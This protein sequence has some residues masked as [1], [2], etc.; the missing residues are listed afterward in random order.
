[1]TTDDFQIVADVLAQSYMARRLEHAVEVGRIA[2]PQS[3][4]GRQLARLRDVALRGDFATRI[5]SMGLLL[6]AAL[7]TRD[8][9]TLFVPRLVRPA[10]SPILQ[11]DVLV[12]SLVL[13]TMAPAV[14]RAWRWSRLRAVV[15]AHR[16][17]AAT[18]TEGAARR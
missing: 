10:L 18:P 12:V 8:V 2:G 13:L 6:L 7:V 17:S 15:G 9:L 4:C 11:T 3:W 14:E 1:M 5:R 16:T